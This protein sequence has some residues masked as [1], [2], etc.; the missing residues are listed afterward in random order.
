MEVKILV[1]NRKNGSMRK[2]CEKY[3]KRDFR[4]IEE[5]MRKIEQDEA[6]IEVRIDAE[7]LL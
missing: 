3:T 6:V 4:Q 5:L 1:R 7:P 2:I